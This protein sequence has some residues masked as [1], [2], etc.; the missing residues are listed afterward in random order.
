MAAED[1]P[2]PRPASG[3]RHSLRAL[4]HRNFAIFFAGALASNT[5]S[6]VQN[7]TVPYVLFQLTRSAT[8]VGL[9]TFAQFLPSVLFGPL[10]GSLADR[11]DRR[12]V[13]V[14]TQIMLMLAAVAMWVTWV[15][16]IRSPALLLVLVATSGML[17]GL[18]I[19]SWQAFVP[20]LV[21]RDDLLSAITLNSLQFNAAR[22]VGSAVAG[23]V[24]TALGVAAAFLANAASFVFVIGALALLRL[25][26]ETPDRVPERGVVRQFAAA[27]RYVGTQPGIVAGMVT[28]VLVAALGNP[29]V[30]FAAVFAEDVFG[31]GTL[32]YGFLAASLGV[33]AL[34]AA[35]VVS[36][37]DTAVPRSTV[38]TVG[39]PF[40]GLACVAFA[41][42]PNFPVAVIAMACAGG[43]FLAVI[44]A[45][46]TAVQVIVADHMRGRV[47]A[48]RVMA[49]T[50]SYALGGL[51]QGVVAQRVGPRV[52]VAVAGGLLLVG[53]AVLR[54]RSA[55]LLRL[56]DPPDTT[57]AP[58]PAA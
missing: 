37:W 45:T 34:L 32:A 4:R 1:D 57:P 58:V 46:N 18:N 24:L 41:L 6:W 35:P 44:S 47:M 43:G 26:R 11:Y 50:V 56:D 12:R 20:R 14:V 8:W 33:G 39:L 42:A 17:G 48:A 13:V 53:A 5:G 51:L 16:G 2:A 15:A 38:V 19:P 29:I 27:L 9:A 28:A 7:A 22:A 30:Q 3:V 36:G 23:L 52:T 55:L 10:G 21:P 31:V 40:Y 49:F 54:F 25:P